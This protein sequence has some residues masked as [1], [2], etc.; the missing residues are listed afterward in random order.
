MHI[1]VRYL[2][3]TLLASAGLG[4]LC[5]A[6][7]ANNIRIN[8]LVIE[9]N[10]LPEADRDRIIRLFQQKTYLQPEIGV[11]IG[12]AFRNL[13]YLR[14]VVDE[15]RVSFPSQGVRRGVAQVTVKVK[16]GT[17]YR[18]GEIHFQKA[19]IFPSTQLRSLFSLRRGEIF[20]EGKIEKGLEDLRK[21]Y[22]TKGYVNL[23][24]VPQTSIDESRRT[25]DLFID[26][27]EGKPY[28]FGKLYLDGVEPYA[29]AGRALLNSWK[30][31]EGK[32]YN[33]LEL[34]HWLVAHHADWKVGTRVSDSMRLAPNPYFFVVNVKLT[35]WPERLIPCN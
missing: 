12:V 4:Q 28:D 33:S 19:T 34:Q 14:I 31:L 29:G 6:Q 32:R 16:Q 20:N 7:E 21:L 18:L 8:K 35:Q 5:F 26:V 27:D 13:G 24:V 22:E 15:P 23:A 30:T 17:Q 25:V 2:V 11:R 1:F 9:S 10:N 3:V